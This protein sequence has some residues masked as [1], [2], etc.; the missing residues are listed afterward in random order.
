MNRN[1]YGNIVLTLLLGAVIFL[2]VMIVNALDRVHAAL[3]DLT[4]AGIVRTD[5]VPAVET[6]QANSAT[7]PTQYWECYAAPITS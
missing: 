1:V 6:Q 3:R 2:G 7:M 5:A 4:A